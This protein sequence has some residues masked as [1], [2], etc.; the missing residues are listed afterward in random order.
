M[1]SQA[2]ALVAGPGIA[3]KV[4]AL[5]QGS[6]YMNLLDDEALQCRVSISTSITQHCKFAYL[7]ARIVLVQS[8][9]LKALILGAFPDTL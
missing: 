2:P 5:V 9:Y 1:G 4:V 6:E 8:Y 3:A 7:V